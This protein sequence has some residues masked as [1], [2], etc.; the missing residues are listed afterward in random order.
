MKIRVAIIGAGH[1]GQTFASYSLLRPDEMQI[2]AVADKKDFLRELMKEKYNI[3]DEMLF[4]DYDD[5]FAAG[6]IAD[7]VC[8]ATQDDQHVDPAI[9]ALETGYKYLMVEK[10][11]DNDDDKCRLLAQKAKECGATVQICHSLRYTAFYRKLKEVLDSGVIGDIATVQH[12]EGLGHFH[13]S[14]SYVRGDWCNSNTS[15]P[16]ILAKCCHDTDLFL[17]LIG[18]NCLSVSSY[19]SLMHFRPENAPEGSSERCIT[20][21]YS[22]TC[23]FSA[24]LYY[25]KFRYEFGPAAIEKEGYTDVTTALTEGRFGKCVYRCNNNVVDHQVVNCLFE[26]GTTATL[27]MT[28]FSDVGRETRIF[29][30]KGEIYARLE[31]DIIKVSDFSTG[32]TTTYTIAHDDSGHSGADTSLVRDFLKVVRGEGEPS[33]PIEI[34]LQS[35]LMCNAAEKSRLN[36]GQVVQIVQG[37]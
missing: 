13:Q 24:T 36:G 33:T 23:P 15:S 34:S 12:L 2:V 26:G 35:H 10:P 20:C 16:M 9:K 3:P 19:G 5:F 27:T 8:I 30:T 25:N 7:A 29:G 1:R 22:H 21:K 32:D 18:K 6:V 14:H 4:E 17:Y 31:G 11:I 28:G 37:I